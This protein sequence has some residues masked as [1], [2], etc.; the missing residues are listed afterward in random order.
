MLAVAAVCLVAGGFVLGRV[1]APK[2]HQAAVVKKSAQIRR[3]KPSRSR[4]TTAAAA[5]SPVVPRAIAQPIQQTLTAR[6]QA[7][8]FSGTAI[9]IKNGK[10]VAST[11]LGQASV[12]RHLAN[13]EDTMFEIDSLQ[14]SLTAGLVIQLLDAGKLKLTTPIG[15]FYPRFK[16]QPRIT[17]GTLLKMRSGLKTVGTLAPKYQSDRQLV[18]YV[19]AHVTDDPHQFGIWQYTAVNYV[20][21]VG[22]VE[23]VTGQSY[24]ALFKQAYIDRLHLKQ[25]VM[26]YHLRP[27]MNY[28][29]GYNVQGQNSY[30]SQQLTSLDQMHAELGTGQVYMSALDFYRAT[31]SLMTGDLLGGTRAQLYRPGQPNLFYDAGFYQNVPGFLRANGSGY[32]YMTT[33]QLSRNGRDAVVILGNVQGRSR[34]GIIALAGQLRQQFLQ[35]K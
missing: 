11:S 10:L 28:A 35:A 7:Q 24:E 31:R 23:K 30:A 34:A 25:T 2:P 9:V 14:K 16:N 4:Q 1:T 13:R 20:L 18:D 21:L 6:L 12:K 8:H 29:S 26:A 33:M 27:T 19:A 32:G 17:V 3:N 22:I 5:A 15:D